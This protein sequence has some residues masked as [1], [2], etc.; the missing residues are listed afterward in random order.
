MRYFFDTEF[1][2]NVHP[3]EL[4]SI[5]IVA[6]DRREFYAVA[7]DYSLAKPFLENPKT[8]DDYPHLWSCNDWVK[9]HVIPHLFEVVETRDTPCRIGTEKFIREELVNFVGDDPYPEFWAWYGDYDWFLL[10]RMFKTFDR[11]PKKWPQICYDVHQYARH[12]GFHRNLPAKFKPEHNALIDAR[13]TQAA[14]N[15]VKERVNLLTDVRE[16][17]IWP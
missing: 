1:N 4:V 12:H 9:K 10:T 14:F 17:V 16:R 2:E 6:D 7:E 5:G 3:I 8:R 15:Q 11:M 13:W